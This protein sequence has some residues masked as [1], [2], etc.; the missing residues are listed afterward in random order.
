MYRFADALKD[1][2]PK[3]R[4]LAMLEAGCPISSSVMMAQADLPV[5]Q[6]R[7]IVDYFL[8]LPAFEDN[9]VPLHERVNRMGVTQSLKRWSPLGVV[10]AIGAYNVPLFTALW[11]VVPG[12]I[13]GN[14]VIVRPNPLTPL[15]AMLFAEAAEEASLPPGALN[16]ITE[17]G[18]DGAQLMTSHRAIDMVSFTGSPVV[19]VKVAQQAATTL[20][21]VVLELGGK[22]AQ[23]FLPDSLEK[24]AA[25]AVQICTSNAGQGCVL[26]TRIFVPEDS[27]AQILEEAAALYAKLKVGVASDT[28][29]QVGPVISAGQRAR[30]EHFTQAAVEHGGRVV[31]GGKRPAHLPKGFFWE[32]TLLD[33]PDNKNPAAQE[34]IFGPVAGIIG[35]RDL[36]HAVE[37]A[38]DTQF[39]LSGYVFGKDK[40][41]ALKV[42]L[43]MRSGMVN[44]NGMLQ[45]V[46]ASAGGI[47][48]SGIGRERGLEGLRE[49]QMLSGLNIGG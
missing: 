19:G 6:A 5:K 31:A 17:A 12:L 8:E 2:I 37:M 42:G 46:R 43:A 15:S 30:C 24:V 29:T 38:N 28:E 49:F 1:R 26:G 45:S 34:E 41:A 21:R 13:A 14:T 16:V 27:K 22:S 25:A 9:P 33:L 48:M 35:Y 23:I 4:E 32:P 40:P 44:V 18:L 20:K 10:S 36:D 39:G 47:K 3:L 7:E 11:K